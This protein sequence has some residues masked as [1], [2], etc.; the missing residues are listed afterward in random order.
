MTSLQVQITDWNTHADLI[1]RVRFTVFVE[2]QKVPRELELDG[3][4]R[5]CEHA[6]ILH[7][8]VPI[9]TGRLL[10]DGHIGRVAVLKEHR[11]C[12]YGELVVTALMN[13]AL[14]LGHKGVELSSQYQAA[15]FYRKL[16]FK[17]QGEVYLEAG[18]Q[19]IYMVHTFS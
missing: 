14:E 13:R 15:N 17:Q 7:N 6:L 19:H 9:A 10:A 16:G 2:E 18:I 5:Q 1:S 3:L 12:G 11:S 8:S 4:D